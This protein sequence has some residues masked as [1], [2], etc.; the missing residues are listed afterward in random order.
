MEKTDLSKK[1]YDYLFEHIV[2]NDFLPG[3]PI[4][5]SEICDF[6]NISRTPVREAI[7]RLEAEGLVYKIK[8][9]GTIV[10]EITYDDIIEIYEIR[11]LFEVHALERCVENITDNEIKLLEHRLLKL[12]A[13]SSEQEYYEVDRDIH[14][15][16][17]KF[18]SNSR[19]VNYL[20]TI[21]AQSEKFRRVSATNPRRL[22]KSREEHLA[23]VQAI[24]NRDYN[25]ASETLIYHLNEVKKN[26]IETYRS[27][28]L[29]NV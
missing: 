26:V 14:N 29:I 11:I 12:D 21:N 17:M 20:K 1:A 23:I 2:A 5:E 25:K 10:R 22:C 9:V 4:V 3:N 8:D 27:F 16:I 6:L 13:S 19:M 15:T 24:Y 28:K 18:C 7:R